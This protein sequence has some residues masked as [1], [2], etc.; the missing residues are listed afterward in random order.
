MVEDITAAC[1]RSLDVLEAIARQGEPPVRTA[2]VTLAE[3]LPESVVQ[4][5]HCRRLLKADF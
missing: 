2:D 5:K 1:R 3:R 4:D